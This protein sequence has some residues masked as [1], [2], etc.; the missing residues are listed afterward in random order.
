MQT[1]SPV[2]VPP[3]KDKNAAWALEEPGGDELGEGILG[4]RDQTI[5][6]ARAQ[7]HQPQ[8]RGRAANPRKPEG[9]GGRAGTA[10]TSQSHRDTPVQSFEVFP[11]PRAVAWTAADRDQSST[12]DHSNQPIITWFWPGM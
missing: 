8:E 1:L 10:R 4:L 3:R 9:D 5:Q 11:A 7:G 2:A 6:S 12:G